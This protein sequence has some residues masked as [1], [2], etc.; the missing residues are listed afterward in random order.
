MNYHPP[1][2]LHT[3][4]TAL[5]LSICVLLCSS[6]SAL[7]ASGTV[8][9]TGEPVNVRSGAGYTSSVI[10]KA[11]KGDR[12]PLLGE[13]KDASGAKWYQI[14]FG[15]QKTG[16]LLAAFA[17]TSSAATT[18]TTKTTATQPTTAPVQKQ[19]R[20]TG[21]TINVRTGCG[22]SFAS[23]G[24][25]RSGETY[26]LLDSAKTDS[27]VTWYK[28]Q[29][30]S[31]KT[32]WVS[33]KYATPM[34]L[35]AVSPSTTSTTKTTTSATKATTSATKTT[36]STTKTTTS[37]TK[38][39][40][41][42]TKTTTTTKPTTTTT[43]PPVP[44]NRLVKVTGTSVNVRT[45][46]GTSF[47]VLGVTSGGYTFRYLGSA[48]GDTG[49]TWYRIQ[50]SSSREGWISSSY[51]KLIDNNTPTNLSAPERQLRDIAQKYGAVGAQ[52]AIIK[53][54]KVTAAYHYGDAVKN[55]RKMTD[56]DKIRIASVSKVF[57][58]MNAMKMQEEGIVSLDTDIGEYW[59]IKTAR[60]TALRQM[61]TH[62]SY[63]RSSGIGYHNYR[64]GTAAQLA[65]PN[66]YRSTNSWVYNNYAVGFAGATLEVAADR[67]LNAY[68]H[69]KFLNPLGIDASFTSGNLRDTG[70]LAALYYPSDSL[71]R[72]VSSAKSYC[73]RPVG[74]N[75]AFFAGGLTI[76]AKDMAKLT[77]ILAND[78]VYDGKRYL[79]AASV[80]EM[81]RIVT[82]GYA[83]GH[84][85]AQAMPLRRLN[86]VYGQKTLY[87]HL[88]D[89]YGTLAMASYNPETKNGAV[90]ITTGASNTYDSYG[91]FCVCAEL[92]NYYLNA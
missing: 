21:G 68:A 55:S 76:S 89:A 35:L 56:D 72:S 9:V 85:F 77:A 74:G 23:I 34:Q 11:H 18:T 61:F 25:A 87:F 13:K 24:I 88:G 82:S 3:A 83:R 51:A 43:Q 70:K 54:G 1:F 58:A 15:A 28:I 60:P 40:T 6:R 79:S 73:E 65:D 14:Q 90:I 48:K 59:N 64:S 36:T 62:T 20:I 41:S 5:L 78:G 39:T 33:G 10:G 44:E 53:N 50:Y 22:T 47:P 27:G 67:S 71:A 17:T 8:R 19:V 81:E 37:T 32:G 46:A 42:A 12:Y 2:R 30:T 45:G 26:R 38:A 16:W 69:E 63:L 84:S 57:I 75:A 31:T 86:N 66:C 80:S 4:L 7:A 29:F 91:T 52:A 49:K 92:A